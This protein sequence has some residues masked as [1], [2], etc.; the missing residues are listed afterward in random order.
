MLT[1][2]FFKKE[3]VIKLQIKKLTRAQRTFVENNNLSTYDW[4]F[5]KDINQ[6]EMQIYNVKT[7]EIRTIQKLNKKIKAS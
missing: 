7:K 2:K 5:I 6:N 3:R 4:N 1:L